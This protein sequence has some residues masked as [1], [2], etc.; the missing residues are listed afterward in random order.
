MTVCPKVGQ[1]V[2]CCRTSICITCWTFGSN[3][4]SG[5][6]GGYAELTR[7]ADDLVAAFQ[8]H[9]DAER[10]RQEMEERLAAFGLRI[11]QEKTAVLRFDGRLLQGRG[12][13]A[14]KP[15]TFTF[16]GFV[17]YLR[18]TRRGTILIDRKPSVVAGAATSKPE[19]QAAL[20]LGNAE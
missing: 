4:A 12:P 19:S 3:D 11:A 2:P 14:E 17:H 6:R 7:F 10:F 1:S 5:R 9:G 8:D 20:R 16:L 18:K 13:P 15:A